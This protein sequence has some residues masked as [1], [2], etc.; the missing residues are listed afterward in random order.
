MDDLLHLCR[1]PDPSSSKRDLLLQLGP[2]SPAFTELLS[3]VARMMQV[4]AL[5]ARGGQQ[6]QDGAAS[7]G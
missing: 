2:G 3:V 6:W 7:G 4:G 5:Q 1:V